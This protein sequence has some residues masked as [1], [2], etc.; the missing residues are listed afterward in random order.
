MVGIKGRSGRKP[1]DSGWIARAVALYIPS[2]VSGTKTIKGK[3]KTISLTEQIKTKDRIVKVYTQVSW[4]RLFKKIYGTRATAVNPYN[5]QEKIRM[6]IR[7]CVIDYTDRNGWFCECSGDRLKRWHFQHD[8]QCNKCGYEPRKLERYRTVAN[9]RA[10]TIAPRTPKA[11]LTICPNHGLPL[12]PI[13]QMVN[14][15]S[16]AVMKCEKCQQ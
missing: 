6:M 9:A 11:K 13:H 3:L 15:V 12:S 10:H 7:A 8:P 4:F 16:T 14:G 1:N 2:F 5:Y